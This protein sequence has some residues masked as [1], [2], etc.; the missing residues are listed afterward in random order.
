MLAI[1]STHAISITQSHYTHSMAAHTNERLTG[2]KRYLHEY[3][4]YVI[5]NIL[6]IKRRYRYDSNCKN[7]PYDTTGNQLYANRCARLHNM[8]DRELSDRPKRY[9]AHVIKC[10]RRQAWQIEKSKTENWRP[11]RR[12]RKYSDAP[13]GIPAFRRQ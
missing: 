7:S 8:R 10:P 9:T 4:E 3:L 12:R 2:I 11:I 5:P 13:Q 6:E 1:I